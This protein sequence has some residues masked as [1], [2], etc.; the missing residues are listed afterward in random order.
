MSLVHAFTHRR[1][2]STFSAEEARRVEQLL[3]EQGIPCRVE[4]HS[5]AQSVTAFGTL[6]EYEVAYDIAVPNEYFEQAS[7]LLP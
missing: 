5:S 3:A 7:A 6:P 1:V 2:H 4:K